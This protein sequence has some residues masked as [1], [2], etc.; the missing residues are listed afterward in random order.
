MKTNIRQNLIEFLL[1][2]EIQYVIKFIHGI[3]QNVGD[4][5]ADKLWADM[6]RANHIGEV[7]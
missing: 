4:E 3:R 1:N 7:A 6:I 5:Y 2:S